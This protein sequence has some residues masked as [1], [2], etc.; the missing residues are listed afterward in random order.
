MHLYQLRLVNYRRFADATINLDSKM[1]A[2]L[3]PNESGKS[4]LLDALALFNNEDRVQP[5]ELRRGSDKS[6]GRLV[7]ELTYRLRDDERL[8]IPYELPESDALWLKV[9]KRVGGTL[10]FDLYPV[11]SRPL[12]ARRAAQ[13]ALAKGTASSWYRRLEA[14]ERDDEEDPLTGSLSMLTGELDTEVEHLAEGL[15]VEMQSAVARLSE[16]NLAERSATAAKAIG[17]LVAKLKAAIELEQFPAPKQL[18]EEIA[19]T[20]PPS[21]FFSEEHRNLT[22]SHDLTNPATVSPAFQN[23]ADFGDLDLFALTD[24]IKTDDSGAKRTLVSKA[25]KRINQRL[26]KEWN[27]SDLIV[28][29]DTNALEDVRITV[30]G[31]D[32]E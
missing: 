5:A 13:A 8:E 14:D 29:L 21:M 2:I 27:Q 6:D 19:A 31:A 3:G 20:R 17:G 1:V 7:G 26:E 24:A 10:E 18:A 9:K 23:L 16:I 4:S 30:A 12:G 11:P 22:F 15:R 28:D 25:V 32:G